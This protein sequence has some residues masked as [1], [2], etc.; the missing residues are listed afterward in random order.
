VE[1]TIFKYIE[2]FKTLYIVLIQKNALK[3]YKKYF[4]I[5]SFKWLLRV[6]TLKW[7][8]LKMQI[9]FELQYIWKLLIKNL[10]PALMRMLSTMPNVLIS[11][12]R[13]CMMNATWS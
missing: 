6:D 7:D 10:R 3:V 12:T 9:P 11:L 5:Q 1:N 8:A 4:E 2:S 13:L